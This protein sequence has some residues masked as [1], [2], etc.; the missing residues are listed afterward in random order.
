[1]PQYLIRYFAQ[2]DARL[3]GFE[4]STTVQLIEHLAATAIVGYVNATAVRDSTQPLPFTP[5]MKG[6]V[7]L[8][9]QDNIY[10]AMIEWRLTAKQDWVGIGETPTAGNGILNLG[11]GVRLPMGGAVHDISIHCDNLLNQRYFDHL[12]VFHTFLSQPARGFR[13]TYDLIF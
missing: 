2:T 7:R 4:V 9:Y 13:L 3:Y 11:F 8:N 12:S 10:A 1:M 5:P 6:L